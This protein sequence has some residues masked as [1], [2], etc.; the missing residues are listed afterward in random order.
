MTVEFIGSSDTNGASEIHPNT[1]P[2]LD[3]RYVEAV[4]KAHEKGGFDRALVA[5]GSTSPESQLVVAHAGAVTEKLGFWSPT[6]PGFIAPT[7]RPA[8]SPR[9]TIS[10][11]AGS[12]CTSS[13][14][15]TTT[16]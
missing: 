10:P 6:G 5:F 14:A 13:P 15:A 7:W 16:R 1:G 12:R 9:S 8:S 4:A 2:V 3:V 11:A